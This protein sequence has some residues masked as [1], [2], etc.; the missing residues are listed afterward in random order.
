MKNYR[1]INK[2]ITQK[3]INTIKHMLWKSKKHDLYPQSIRKT[4]NRFKEAENRLF[5][6]LLNK[7]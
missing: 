7:N 4:Q 5:K 3:R 2:R 1:D 6:G